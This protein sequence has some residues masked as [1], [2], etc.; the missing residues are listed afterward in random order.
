[1]LTKRQEWNPKTKKMTSRAGKFFRKC[2]V[3]G[4]KNLTFISLQCGKTLGVEL[5][6]RGWFSM[7]G[8]IVI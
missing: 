7:A 8:E 2:P 6:H 4:V 1:M 5:Y 3:N